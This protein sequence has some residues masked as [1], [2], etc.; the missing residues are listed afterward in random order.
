[1]RYL[2]A[3]VA[4]LNAAT[5]AAARHA[6]ASWSTIDGMLITSGKAA[7]TPHTANIITA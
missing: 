5:V 2:M 4:A 3:G 6:G 1:M 7:R